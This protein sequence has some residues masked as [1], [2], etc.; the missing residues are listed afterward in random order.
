MNPATN[1]QLCRRTP[2][3]AEEREGL[4]AIFEDGLIKL[5]E[6]DV[7][8]P[9]T[10]FEAVGEDAPPLVLEIYIDETAAAGYRPLFCADVSSSYLLEV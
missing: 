6:E 10:G 5:G 4:E 8:V 3:K 7:G 9:V 1:H 2:M